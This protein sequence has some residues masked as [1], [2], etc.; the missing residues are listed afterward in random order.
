MDVALGEIICL[1]E[2]E[3]SAPCLGRSKLNRSEHIIPVAS[4]AE[5]SFQLRR[6]AAESTS[7]DR[8]VVKVAACEWKQFH[9]L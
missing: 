1:L 2:I 9:R 4:P 6:E 3:I 5:H 8:R 7:C